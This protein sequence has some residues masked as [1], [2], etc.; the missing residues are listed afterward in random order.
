MG[1]S[2]PTDALDLIGKI[3]DTGGDL[4][5]TAQD[6]EQR[7]DPDPSPDIP[8]SQVPVQLPNVDYD[9]SLS[10]NNKKDDDESKTNYTPWLIGGAALLGI[11]LLAK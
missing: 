4:V 1:L 9:G 8:A 10:V 5:G 6:I 3:V 7:F 2:G 11:W